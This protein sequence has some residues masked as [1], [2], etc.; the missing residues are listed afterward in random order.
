MRAASADL[1]SKSRSWDFDRAC[2]RFAA[3]CCG[4]CY[5]VRRAAPVPTR[6]HFSWLRSRRPIMVYA[7]PLR[8][9]FSGREQQGCFRGRYPTVH[10]IA[11][12]IRRPICCKAAAAG[13]SLGIT[14]S[15]SRWIELARYGSCKT[16]TPKTLTFGRSVKRGTTS[17]I[18]RSC[19]SPFVTFRVL[20]SR[21]AASDSSIGDRRSTAYSVLRVIRSVLRKVNV[22]NADG[23]ALLIL[24]G[25]K[26]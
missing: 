3:T 10:T 6:R 22:Q 11:G 4:E 20:R 15:S 18:V 24:I 1:A 8:A 14:Q 26:A 23:S 12:D 2:R 16:A 19:F 21:R 9:T 13:T 25:R 5:C 7:L 17:F